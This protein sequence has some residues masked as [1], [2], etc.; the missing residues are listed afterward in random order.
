MASSSESSRRT[1]VLPT[2][3]VV[4]AARL[5]PIGLLKPGPGT[6]GSV[7][8]VGYFYA[9]VAPLGVLGVVLVNIVGLAL[10]VFFCG[11]AEERLQQRDPG[12][13]ILDEFVA[14]PLCFLGWPLGLGLAPA[15]VILL[16]GFVLFR[17]FDIT[18]PFGISRLQTLPGGWGVVADDLAAA[19]ATCGCLHLARVLWIATQAVPG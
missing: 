8:G 19:L 3:L 1:Y 5:G 10:A 9:C 4:G 14:I 16:A 13:I 12:E 2:W 17:L 18:K 11:E 15:W 6:W 7:A